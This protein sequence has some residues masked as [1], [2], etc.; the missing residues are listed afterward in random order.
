MIDTTRTT[1][2][3]LEAYH[4]MIYFSPE[5]A[6]AYKELGL[7]GRAGY[8]ASR[9][10]AF[11]PVPAEVVVA[12]FFNFNPV[13]VRAAIPAAWSVTTPEALVAARVDAADHALRRGL[14]ELVG[15]VSELADLARI[16][17]ERAC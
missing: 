6:K 12:T 15:G 7:N 10:A 17:A 3:A 14:G 13:A 8:F 11:G 2:R 1:W 5:A 9:S 4:G 16:A